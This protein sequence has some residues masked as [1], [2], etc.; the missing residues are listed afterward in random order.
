MLLS[1]CFLMRRFLARRIAVWVAVLSLVFLVGCS[2]TSLVKTYDGPAVDVSRS[3][4][5]SVADGIEIISVNGKKVKSYLLPQLDINYQ[6]LPGENSVVFTHE[7]LWAKPGKKEDGGSNSELVVTKPM[8]VSF[9]AKA[10]EVYH[11]TFGQPETRAEA[12]DFAKTFK[13]TLVDSSEGF[14][15]ESMLYSE[16][17]SV[18]SE[19]A[20]T[21]VSGASVGTTVGASSSA[22]AASNVP[23]A[24]AGAAVGVA[25]AS[26]SPST[27]GATT[28]GTAQGGALPTIDGLKVL[29]D[30]ASTNEKKE[31]LKWAF[32]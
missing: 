18:S 15:A 16:A 19:V 1:G 23:V 6:I 11:F 24:V 13:A 12:Y 14:I 29:W 7:T 10:G 5:L 4:I 17:G 22:A 8:Q 21:S 31:F 9:S 32:K 30:S 28:A 2:S 3:A 25:V 27:A 20:S 26:S